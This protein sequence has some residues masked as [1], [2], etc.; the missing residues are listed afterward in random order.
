MNIKVSTATLLHALLIAG[1]VLNLV[2]G[3]V[4]QKY[5]VFVSAGLAAIQMAVGRL[6]HNSPPPVK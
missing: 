5:Q 1:Q 3:V 2:S 6:Q 4:P